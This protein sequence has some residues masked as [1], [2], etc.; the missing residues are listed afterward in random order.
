MLN[1]TLTAKV[2]V[3]CEPE[4]RNPILAIQLKREPGLGEQRTEM[5]A[6]TPETLPR[7]F[8]TKEGVSIR[9]D[10]GV[11]NPAGAEVLSSSFLCGDK[12]GPGQETALS[13]HC[14]L[15]RLKEAFKFS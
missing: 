13:K 4:I 3:C 15:L 12:S 10:T 2:F 8:Q 5:D 9:G 11:I 7:V 14:I 6:S 1:L